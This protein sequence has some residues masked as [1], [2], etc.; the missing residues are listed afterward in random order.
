MC[1]RT[2]TT[3]T[4]QLLAPEA[5]LFFSGWPPIGPRALQSPGRGWE[6]GFSDGRV[7]QGRGL[8]GSV[9]L[10]PSPVRPNPGV[11]PALPVCAGVGHAES[12]TI[13][14]PQGR[15]DR[16]QRAVGSDDALPWAEEKSLASGQAGQGGKGCWGSP[17]APCSSVSTVQPWTLSFHCT[18]WPWAGG[19]TSLGFAS[20]SLQAGAR[21][22]LRVLQHRQGPID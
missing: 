3:P 4:P 16:G 20:S 1:Q 12:Y 6:A 18:V 10:S 15:K 21:P 19:Q 2:T 14:A 17:H 7:S 11:P 13:S 9:G 22:G 5:P 8:R